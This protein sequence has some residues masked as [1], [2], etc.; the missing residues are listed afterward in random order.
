[1]KVYVVSLNHPDGSE[2][3]GTFSNLGFA[4]RQCVLTLNQMETCRIVMIL[5]TATGWTFYCTDDKNQID[6]QIDIDAMTLNGF[7]A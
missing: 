5:W 3:Q 2:L 7:T 4:A 1:M 6:F